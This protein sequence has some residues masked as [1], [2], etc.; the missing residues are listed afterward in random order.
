MQK[1]IREVVK[2]VF[3]RR[4]LTDYGPVELGSHK[5]KHDS[6]VLGIAT[7]K[8][9]T[10]TKTTSIKNATE[11]M[12]KNGIRR[13][14]VVDPGTKRLVGIFTARDILDF[15]GGGKKANLV[16]DNIRKSINT[17]V[18]KIMGARVQTIPD[19]FTIRQTVDFF[20]KND[21]SG[22]PIVDKQRIVKGMITERDLV[23]LTAG[24]PAGIKVEQAMSK[25]TTTSTPGVSISDLAKIMMRNDFRRLPVVSDD[26]IVGMVTSMDIIRVIA[27]NKIFGQDLR[28]ED[29]MVTNPITVQ[30]GL[31]IGELAKLSV[32]KRIGAFPV[33][34]RERLV[35]LITEHDILKAVV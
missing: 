28:V 6:E 11:L 9:V 14:P 5:T 24:V 21:I 29:I 20:R 34:S 25:K 4:K 23:R 35:G 30:P 31:D 22:A 3:D 27:N 10:V 1:R 8:L 19:N 13:M 17:P 12:A 7:K 32:Q 26:R 18:G 16:R 33:A 15:L 2:R